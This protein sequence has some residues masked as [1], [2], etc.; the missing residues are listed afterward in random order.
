MQ[1]LIVDIETRPNLAYVW[2]L[3]NQN[4]GLNQI[5]ETGQ[6]ISFAAKWHGSKNVIFKSDFHD[7][8]EAMVQSA[9]E[10]L[11]KADAVVHYNGKAFD[12]KHLN[13]EF[14]VAHMPPPSP[15]VDIDLLSTV[16]KSFKFPS[17]KLQHV[18]TQLEL[19]SKVQHDG[20]DL[21]L[22]CMNNEEKAWNIMRKYNKQDVVLTEQ[23][24][25]NCCRGLN[26][27][28]IVRCRIIRLLH[29]HGVR[30]RRFKNVDSNT[31]TLRCTNNSVAT[32]ATDILG[33]VR[34]NRHERKPDDVSAIQNM[35]THICA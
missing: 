23:L 16:K 3:W 1:I 31:Q 21:W 13:R 8:H 30:Q 27:I 2:G 6:V 14:V 18:A 35:D 19:G 17:N 4:I 10:L 22:A 28:R 33:H 15:H 25:T 26:R 24:S 12:I 11:D 9:W 32:H 20:F 7:G 29:V 5:S 34:L